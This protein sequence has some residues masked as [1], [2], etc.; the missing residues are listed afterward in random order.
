MSVRRVIWGFIGAMCC[1]H[2]AQAREQGQVVWV[3]ASCDHF[4]ARVGEEF[5]TYN[6]RSGKGPSVGDTMEG[7][8]L[9]LQGGARDVTNKNTGGANSVYV[10]ALGPRLHSMIHTAP[11]QCKERF[12]GAVK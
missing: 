10:L 7:E 4:I 5:G 12:R 8:L 2:I 11:V 1:M 9:D 6:W 3:D